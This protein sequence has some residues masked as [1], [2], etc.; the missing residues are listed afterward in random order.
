MATSWDVGITDD[1]KNDLRKLDKGSQR[2]VMSAI[3]DVARRLAESDG[4]YGKPLG[5]QNGVDLS[6]CYKIRTGNLRVVYTVERHDEAMTV[7]VV[8]A[9]ADKAVYREA[10]KRLDR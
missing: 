7:V 10:A 6:G 2:R 3:A 8:G 9:R 4:R 5:N 1:A